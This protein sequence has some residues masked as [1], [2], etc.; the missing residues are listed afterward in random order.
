M[1]TKHNTIAF[2]VISYL[3]IAT[4][5]FLYIHSKVDFRVLFSLTAAS[6]Q[7]LSSSEFNIVSVILIFAVGACIC[8]VLSL[9]MAVNG[10]DLNNAST[11]F[12]F[13]SRTMQIHDRKRKHS[14]AS[15]SLI[16]L[17]SLTL[18]LTLCSYRPK[19][20][21]AL[22]L[23]FLWCIFRLGIWVLLRQLYS[24][25]YSSCP[26]LSWHTK[27]PPGGMSLFSRS[28]SSFV[29]GGCSS[30]LQGRRELQEQVM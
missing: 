4:F 12:G 3:L 15:F 11:F 19:P 5:T 9:G 22:C 28:G 14:E 23:K 2:S 27:C 16:T 29:T 20:L 25:Y 18:L 6:P 13:V 17:E 8:L 1:R 7:P 26:T 21:F 24:G 30:G 10:Q